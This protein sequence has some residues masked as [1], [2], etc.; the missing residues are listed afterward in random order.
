M[1]F[2][3]PGAVAESDSAI[4]P[5]SGA[6]QQSPGWPGPV[7]TLGFWIREAVGL[8]AVAAWV[9]GTLWLLA[10]LPV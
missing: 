2:L 10:I 4:R 8:A 3:A 6:R 7:A 5:P 9:A 1:L